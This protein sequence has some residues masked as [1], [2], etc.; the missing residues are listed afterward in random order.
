MSALCNSCGADIFWVRTKNGARMPLDAM[1]ALDGNLE[2]RGNV[3]VFVTPDA[4]A[5]ESRYKSHFATCPNA[6]QHRKRK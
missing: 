6:S 2:L 3:A 1:P 4:N 5:V